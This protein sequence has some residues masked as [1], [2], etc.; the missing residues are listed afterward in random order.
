M[1]NALALENQF[2]SI[3]EAFSYGSQALELSAN[4]G[5]VYGEA[6][7]YRNLG[8]SYAIRQDFVTALQLLEKAE[9]LFE[10]IGSERGIADCYIS[11]GHVYRWQLN[12]D[13][14][15]EYQQKA[16]GIYKKLGMPDRY[17]VAIHNLGE[18][19][20]LVGRLDEA[21]KTT[22]EAIK[23]F[24]EIDN[25]QT[26]TSCLKVFGLIAWERH[27]L[28]TS[29]QYFKKALAISDELGADSQKEAS[30]DCYLMLAKIYHERQQK[31][32]EE[33][34]LKAA[35]VLAD[36]NVLLS[37]QRQA[38]SQLINYYFFYRQFEQAHKTFEIFNELNEQ[39][40]DQQKVEM[41]NMMEQV[42]Q[43][44]QV[45]NENEILKKEKL[46]QEDRIEIQRYQIY[47]F[48]V[49]ILLL[50]ILAFFVIRNN[51]QRRRY[52]QELSERNS[53]I[54]EKSQ[55]LEELVE[56]KDKF[57]SI[58]SHDLRSP[59]ST[60]SQFV[61][62]L[63]ASYKDFTDEEMEEV[64]E[65]FDGQLSSTL[66]L[67]DDIILWAKSEINQLPGTK[68]AFEINQA[69]EAVMRV[70]AEQVRMKGIALQT[71]FKNKLLVMGNKDQLEF[72]IRN[73][74]SNS[75]KF[76]PTG[77]HIG[78]DVVSEGDMVAVKVS[79]S[80]TGISKEKQDLLF[81]SPLKQ[82]QSELG[83]SGEKGKGLGLYL[84]ND[85]I[86]KNGGR[87]EVTSEPGKGSVFT[88]YIPVAKAS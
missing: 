3:L 61:V 24:Q 29:E 39:I 67:T 50:S 21:E 25:K 82:N 63:K 23:I 33:R 79:D 83:T 62:L 1:L 9:T 56:V 11:I 69:I 64:L 80:G 44:I 88:L 28:A 13:A 47:F 77:G 78:I 73:V 40:F 22:E 43:T 36:E 46:I 17:G 81:Q 84:V 19:Y 6:Y 15:I 4:I 70:T 52:N 74:L 37:Q 7:A 20:L 8:S 58:I 2:V 26:E 66:Q 53:L 57:F 16:A 45:A 75:I 38:Y 34:M 49:S 32:E 72:C 76:T 54:E 18:N 85:F 41:A 5:Y 35:L 10:S 42:L 87:V 65:K 27:D 55:R 48:A 59:I 12:Y 30:F 60:L 51:R 14:A 71:E 68:D 86:K 31:A